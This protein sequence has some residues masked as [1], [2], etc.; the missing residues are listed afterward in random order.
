MNKTILI[1]LITCVGN[2][3]HATSQVPER[4]SYN[5]VLWDMYSIPLQSFFSEDKPKPKVFY[6]R[7]TSTACWRGYV[8]NWQIKNSKLYLVGLKEGYPSTDEISLYSVNPEWV[9]PVFANW[10]T[11]S[12]RIGKGKVLIGGMGFSQ[13]REIEVYLDIKNGNLKS[14]RHVDNTKEEEKAQ[15]VVRVND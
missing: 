3:V 12:I 13:K 6:E 7:A 15:P 2:L 8:G 5:G 1:I 11:G 9:S 10:F 14:I 4:V